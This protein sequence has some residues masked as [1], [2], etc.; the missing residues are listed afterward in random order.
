[1]SIS[2]EIARITK[3]ISDS[4]DAVAAK[5]VVVPSGSNSDDLPELIAQ[6]TSGSGGGSGAISIIDTPDAGGGVVRT[7]TAVDISD[8]TAAAADVASGKYF[9]T[10]EGVKTAGTA[11]GGASNYVTGTFKGTTTGA[12]MDVNI[13]Y[14]GNGYP[15]VVMIYVSGG[16]RDADGT[17]E[18]LIQRYATAE[19]LATKADISEAPEYR[20]TA[21]YAADFAAVISMYKNSSTDASSYTSGRSASQTLYRNSTRASSSSALE[22]VKFLPNNIMSVY[23]ASTSYGFAANYDY[24]YH[25]IYSS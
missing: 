3:N 20:N 23:I 10:S 22:I 25:I 4:L 14:T 15:I 1:M 5:G 6:I 16:I 13:P 7:I 12:A 11:T 18:N 24:T 19:L 8:T 17:F 9:Y 2:S 21:N